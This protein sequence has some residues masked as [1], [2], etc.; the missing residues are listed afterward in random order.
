VKT[1]TAAALSLPLILALPSSAQ[2]AANAPAN[3]ESRWIQNIA[4]EEMWKR[5]TLCVFPTDSALAFNSHIAGTVD[6][7][8]GISPDGDVAIHRVLD[9]QPFLVQSAVD[10]IRQWKF[11]PN[12][13][14]GEV[15]WSRVRALVRFNA[16]GTT[17]VDLSPALLAD[18]FGDPGTTRATAGTF[19]R[20]A[21]TP[22]CKSVQRWTGA[23]AKEIEASELSPGFYENNDFGLTFHFPSEWQVAD[24][25]TLDS[26]DANRKKSAKSQ[27][28]GLPQNVQLTML[29]SYLL[30]FARTDGPIASPGPSVQIWAEKEVFIHS[31]TEYFPNTQFLGDKNAD[32]TSGP[33]EIEVSGTK[34]YRGNRWGKAEGR[35]IYQVLLVTY[36]RDSIV[37]IAVIADTAATA[38]R[39]VKS[40][41][42]L[43]IIPPH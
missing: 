22:E 16:D 10:A 38:E 19:P 28:S 39:L 42:G 26:I 23:E 15:T 6:F 20:P 21:S 36:V 12:V 1:L 35:S 18:D 40:L 3:T 17:G 8:L 27:Y 25:D 9:G 41:E 13:V 5:V 37:G 30:F 29:P 14:R 7:G 4:P 33:E 2:V 43:K 34:Y 31:A 11:R 32:G 24:R